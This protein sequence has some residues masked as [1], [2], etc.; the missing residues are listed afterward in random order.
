METYIL[1]MQWPDSQTIRV[2]KELKNFAEA[3]RWRDNCA[4]ICGRN[5][6]GTLFSLVTVA[7]LQLTSPRSCPSR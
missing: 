7:P 2:S 3:K 4:A 1:E 6:H 5:E